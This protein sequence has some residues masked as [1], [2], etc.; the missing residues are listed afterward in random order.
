MGAGN[1]DSCLPGQDLLS[2]KLQLLILASQGP[3]QAAWAPAGTSWPEFSGGRR[4]EPGLVTGCLQPGCLEHGREREE[5]V[6]GSRV[7][8][9]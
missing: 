7:L 9:L 8:W 4:R 2:A 6:L 1:R 5:R 3:A